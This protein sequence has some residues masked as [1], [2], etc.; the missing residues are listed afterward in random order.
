MALPTNSGIPSEALVVGLLQERGG[1]VDELARPAVEGLREGLAVHRDEHGPVGE[2]REAAPADAGDDQVVAEVDAVLLLGPEVRDGPVLLRVGRRGDA[3][4]PACARHIVTGEAEDG[5][6]LVVFRGS[7]DAPA[8]VRGRGLDLRLDGHEQVA[9]HGG[10]VDHLVH[11]V[12]RD[13]ELPLET[14]ATPVDQPQGVE[15]VVAVAQDEDIAVRVSDGDLHPVG[16]P[17]DIGEAP[18]APLRPADVVDREVQAGLVLA[19]DGADDRRAVVVRDQHLVGAVGVHAARDPE[20][21]EAH[22]DPNDPAQL[23]GG[24]RAPA[25]LVGEALRMRLPVSIFSSLVH[26]V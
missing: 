2:D 20:G 6:E 4:A 7:V 16:P 19:D 1:D 3:V 26:V 25:L 9:H 5:V 22:P 15:V 13:V 21:L 24:D 8:P 11:L 23:L 12:N 18:H 10:R 17:L 14:E